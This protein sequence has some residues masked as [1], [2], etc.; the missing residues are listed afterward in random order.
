MARPANRIAL[1][2][3]NCRACSCLLPLLFLTL[4]LFPVRA[5]HA[6]SF[7]VQPI[8]VE[9]SE[10]Q[11]SAVIQVENN[12]DMPVTIQ[13]SSL[14]WSQADGKDQT[15]PTREIIVTPQ[16]FRLNP[17]ARQVLRVGTLRKPDPAQE[18]AYRLLLEEIPPP[19]AADFKG[20]QVALRISM[21]VF[22]KPVAD[23]REKI[24]ATLAMDT[25]RQLRLTLS[26]SGKASAH[27]SE[28][29]LFSEDA[30]DKVIAIQTGSNYV[31]PG[32]QREWQLKASAF[33]PD[34]K[35]L[36]RARTHAGLVEFHAVPVSR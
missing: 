31:L 21:P 2:W 19:P 22:L 11:S 27:F 26:N 25:P 4:S 3:L 36:I 14:A 12:G 34:K 10:R 15:T 7:A 18:S 20:L 13:A 6:G 9:L 24:E 1:H 28:L 35:M 16:I 29:A 30:P 5:V 33:D 23:A 8:R 17:G 32:Q